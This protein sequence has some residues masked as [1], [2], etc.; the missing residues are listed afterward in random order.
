[1]SLAVA[2]AAA[3]RDRAAPRRRKQLRGALLW[4]MAFSGAFV[5]IE[6]SPYEVVGLLTIFIFAVTGLS[7]P[8]PLAPLLLLLILLNIGYAVAVMQVIDQPKPVIWVGVSA[9]LAVT[10]IFYAAAVSANTEETARPHHARL[11]GGGRDRRRWSRSP[12]I[13]T[14]S[15]RFRRC[16]CA[17][18]A[19]GAPSMIP[20]CSAPS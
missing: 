18:A 20:T 11:P 12:P 1:M 14:C 19:H 2:A 15:G 9:Y 7:L 13:S 5:F 10:A 6:P 8:R 17:I 4:L 3:A 16:S